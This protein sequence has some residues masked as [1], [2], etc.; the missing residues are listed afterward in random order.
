MV[1]PPVAEFSLVCQNYRQLTCG[2][3]RTWEH[4]AVCRGTEWELGTDRTF[5]RSWA[6]L[7]SA[8]QGRAGQGRAGQGRAGL[9]WAKATGSN[10]RRNWQQTEHNVTQQHRATRLRCNAARRNYCTHQHSDSEKYMSAEQ[11]IGRCT[12]DQSYT[13]SNASTKTV[14]SPAPQSQLGAPPESE[15]QLA[16]KISPVRAQTSH[17]S[18]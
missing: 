10:R 1:R 15:Q 14:P 2:G 4:V 3:E 13:S 8:G 5:A 11:N 9:A 6:G 7:G 16:F 18:D 12:L 17:R